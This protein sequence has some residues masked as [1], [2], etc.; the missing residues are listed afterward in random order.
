MWKSYLNLI[1]SLSI[2][3]LPEFAFSVYQNNNIDGSYITIKYQPTV[4][5]FKS[6]HIRETG[7]DSAEP[8]GLSQF[9]ANTELNSLNNNY[10]FSTT[11]QTD[12]YKSYKNDLLGLGLSIGLLVRNFRVEFE[13]SYKNFDTKRLAYYQAKEGYKYFAIP[14]H[15]LHGFMPLKETTTSGYNQG[16][17]IAKSNG[18]SIISNIINLCREAK[19]KSFTPYICLGV[20]GDFIEIF[21]AMR[22]KFAY[23]GKVGISYPITSNLV[24]SINGQYHKVIGDKFKLLP[25][26]LPVSLKNNISATTTHEQLDATALLTLNLEHFSSEIGLSFIF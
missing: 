3:L 2:L 10:N 8:V 15:L 19:Y 14:R 12:S 20:G 21:D 11:R 17:I 6:F 22:I 1:I 25:V 4:P 18:I 16:Y 26:F 13:G 5:H 9:V 23:Q 24:L 7:F